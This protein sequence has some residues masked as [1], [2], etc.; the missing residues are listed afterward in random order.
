MKSR[1]AVCADLLMRKSEPFAY[2]NFLALRKALGGCESVL[3]IG[4]SCSNTMRTIGVP[5]TTGLEGYKPFA[6][7]A[8]ELRTQDQVVHGNIKDLGSYFQPKQFDACV[9]IDV[10]EHFSKEDGMKLMHSMEQIARKRVVIFTPNGFLPQGHTAEDDF[11]VH[12]S[13]WETDEM[14]SYGYEVYGALGPKKLR[15]EYHRLKYRPRFFWGAV[16]LLGHFAW[17]RWNPE[18]AAAVLCVKEL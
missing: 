9:A 6:D 16:S 11:E 1:A 7:K 18:E 17:T 5:V 12:L 2:L 10:I 3:D 4:C 15:G 14:R 8:R 13:G